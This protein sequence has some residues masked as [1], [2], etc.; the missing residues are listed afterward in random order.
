MAESDQAS[1]AP[2]VSF[3]VPCYNSHEFLG[4]TLESIHAQTC[5]DFEIILVDD[6]SDTPETIAYLDQIKDDVTLIRQ[7]N[8]GL[9]AARNIGFEKARGHYVLPLDCDDWIDPDF[10]EKTVPILDSQPEFA[11][12][13]ASFH[14]EG[15]AC[16]ILR[17]HYN[18]NEQLYVNQ[19][20]YCILL[21]R[22]A[23]VQAGG[24]DET[25]RLGLEDWEFNIR[26]GTLGL[27]GHGLADPLFHYRVR[28]GGM[29]RSITLTRFSQ[30]Y[31]SIRE[32]H[33]E[34]Y[35]LNS[36]FQ[37][38]TTWRRHPSSYSIFVLAVW[39]LAHKGLP[40]PMMN[41]LV[42]WLKIFSHSS[43]SSRSYK[44]QL[45]TG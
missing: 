35:T 20:P 44:R 32:K 34:H 29:L 40:S 14:L 28:A 7:E 41:R 16:G 43:R 5:R 37:T 36:L 26:L 13:F 42:S 45:G 15:E 8:R 30:I 33:S 1:K 18:Y 19:V 27:H 6:G 38:W 2:A 31:R 23:W 10:L 21:R 9:S 4:Q 22:S 24:Y 25:M 11:F 12:I 39:L 3:V 17:K